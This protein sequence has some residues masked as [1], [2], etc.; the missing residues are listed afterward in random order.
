MSEMSHVCECCR[1][2]P[3]LST[4]PF[5]LCLNC[6]G[7]VNAGTLTPRE[8]YNL[9]VF[10]G[11]HHP[12]LS[13]K[14]YYQDGEA[15]VCFTDSPLTE[16]DKIPVLDNI[17]NYVNDLLEFYFFPW[18]DPATV[19]QRDLIITTI[20]VD[21]ILSFLDKIIATKV[22]HHAWSY[23]YK[24]YGQFVGSKNP[25]WIKQQLQANF[26][27]AYK[28]SVSKS[29]RHMLTQPSVV[30]SL[31][32]AALTSLPPQQIM[33]LTQAARN[34][35]PDVGLSLLK[36]TEFSDEAL[37]WLENNVTEPYSP[38]GAVVAPLNL[39]WERAEKWIV[40]GRPMSLVAM[41]AFHFMAKSATVK[42]LLP[43]DEAHMTQVMNDYQKTDIKVAGWIKSINQNW[44][45]ITGKIPVVEVKYPTVDRRY[46]GLRRL[47]IS[48]KIR[49][50]KIIEFVTE[51]TMG[52]MHTKFGG[53]PDWLD[54]VEWPVTPISKQPMR[55]LGQILLDPVLFP[56]AAGKMIY[57]FLDNTVEDDCG[58]VVLQPN[59]PMQILTQPLT[60]GPTVSDVPYYIVTQWVDEPIY[61]P[62]SAL[63]TVYSEQQR[64]EYRERIN[65]NKM[66]GVP[67][68][69]E[70][71]DFPSKHKEWDLVLQLSMEN[72]PFFVDFG[73][74]GTGYVFLSA[75]GKLAK[76]L[77][78]CY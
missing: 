43:A 40:K 53:Q 13:D 24:M 27:I 63:Y 76:V 69:I 70:G 67:C 16:N 46:Q 17:K 59:N 18:S 52:M 8:W 72:L 74:A 54:K 37:T 58:A 64:Q 10:H 39:T 29:R 65:H 68:F 33:Q 61:L 19:E 6:Q 41:S 62:E 45:K 14:Y 51:K 35:Y 77:V 66:G 20:P 2:A 55:F 11:G 48:R 44:S 47:R 22:T 25:E 15:V 49:S 28:L 1:I 12:L 21:L 50:Q 32:A 38:W 42:L 78:Q 3:A 75:D 23:C 9:V 36:F 71:E 5:L 56:Q 7:N 60:S 73:D 31:L 4:E 30:K 57:I 34:L 26:D